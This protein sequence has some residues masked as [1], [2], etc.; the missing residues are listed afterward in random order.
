[1]K[2][3]LFT[4]ILI[5]VFLTAYDSF[6]QYNNEKSSGNAP[7]LPDNGFYSGNTV[8]T[9]P[10]SIG[11][12][13]YAVGTTGSQLFKY[14]IGAPGSTTLI[15]SVQP[16]VLG[17]GD[18]ANPTGVWKFYVEDQN[19]SPYMIYEVDTATGNLT[20]VGAPLNLKSGH[21]PTDLEWDQTS[22]TF[23]I[24]STNAAL[25]E[26]QLYRMYWPTKELTWVGPPVTSPSSVIAGGFNANGTYFGI[27]INSSSLWKV[28]K[29][30]GSWTNVG[31]LGY[32]VNYAQDAG[33]D[34]SDYSKMLWCACGGTVG[35]YEVDTSNAGINLIGTFPSYTQVMA[36]GFAGGQCGPLINFIPYPNT[37]N[38]TGPYVINITSVPCNSG[39]ASAKLFWSRNNPAITDSV[40]MTNTGGNNWSGS[41]PGNGLPATYRYYCRVADSLNRLAFVPIGAPVNTYIFLALGAD[42]IKPVI[43]H[44]PIGSTSRDNWPA[45]ITASVTDN[46]GI[47]SVWVKWRRNNDAVTHLRLPKITGNVYSS[48]F[49]SIINDVYV[50]DTIYYR[51]IAQDNSGNHNKDSTAL[52][53]FRITSGLYTCI[54]SG[55][56]QLTFAPFNTVYYGCRT[57]L[58]W[59]AQ[60]II[61]AGGSAGFITKIGF[62]IGSADTITMH[63]FTVKMQEVSD[64]AINS[65]VEVNWNTVYSGNYK[66]PAVGWQYITL[67][68]PF[69]WSGF[70]NVLIQTCFENQTKSMYST[71]RGFSTSSRKLAAESHDL[72]NAC[73]AFQSPT[74]GGSRPNVCF[75]I[76]STVG[77][78]NLQGLIPAD[79]KLCQNYPN[80]FNPA[81]RISFEIPLQGYVSLKV[82]DLL[83]R[84]VKTLVSEVKSPGTYYVD[85]DGSGLSSG[86]YFYRL[87]S[88]GFSATK[89]MIVIK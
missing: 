80:P 26:I 78:G 67:Q 1:M 36:T 24:V 4:I 40:N 27:D 45:T 49:N 33:F 62:N 2:K 51:I 20:S 15:G 66:V 22:N 88:E 5:S 41:I 53:A 30:T 14:K 34:R 50:G 60:E 52:Y 11:Y 3:F 32:P 75:A 65:F 38:L 63:N 18:F 16:Y 44:T 68:T 47:D 10:N 69:E 71:V 43:T 54:G 28:N 42:T 29:N 31:S 76:I 6:S 13:Y 39:I 48:A 87:E 70:G 19:T 58:L 89:K 61:A 85:F 35:L 12:S 23:Y 21:K 79:Y 59:T 77:Q 83:G 82:Y 8:L 81:T 25:T 72:S 17:S 57:Q 55:N 73:T 56:V 46:F 7:W 84:E 37:S 9:N 64:T 86:M 74:L